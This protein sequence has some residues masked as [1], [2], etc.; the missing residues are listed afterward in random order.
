MAHTGEA[1]VM[2]LEPQKMAFAPS[3][4][5]IEIGGQLELTLAVSAFTGKF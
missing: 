1:I 4:V 3:K 2:V 5:E